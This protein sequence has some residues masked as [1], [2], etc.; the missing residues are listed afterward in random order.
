M[1]EKISNKELEE[2]GKKLDALIILNLFPNLSGDEKIEVIKHAIGVKP[3][4]KILGRDPSNLR[5]FI[6]NGK[7]A[8][9]D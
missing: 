7:E 4:A 1:E 5:K 3:L 8:G 9:K 2:V 6:K